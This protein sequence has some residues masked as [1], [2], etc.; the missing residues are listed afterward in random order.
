MAHLITATLVLL[1]AGATLAWMAVLSHPTG[2]ALPPLPLLTYILVGALLS[3]YGFVV[4]AAYARRVP[5]PVTI[6]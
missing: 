2:G 3:A 4:L 1:G 5:A 6:D